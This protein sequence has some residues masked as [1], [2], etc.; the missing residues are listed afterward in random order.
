M[1]RAPRAFRRPL[2][3]SK[4]NSSSELS[5]RLAGA[6]SFGTNAIMLASGSPSIRRSDASTKRLAIVARSATADSAKTG[7]KLRGSSCRL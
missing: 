2:G 5:S 6:A 3:S 1:A 7:L 4:L